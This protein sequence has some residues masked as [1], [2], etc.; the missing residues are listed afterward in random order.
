MKNACTSG[1]RAVTLVSVLGLLLLAAG[2]ACGGSR[3]SRPMTAQ[4]AAWAQYL[5]KWYPA[6][7]PPESSPTRKR[8]GTILRNGDAPDIETVPAGDSDFAPAEVP[9]GAAGVE[10]TLLPPAA[11]PAL[12]P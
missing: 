2:C 8:G 10:P 3:P 11:E 5:Q 6:W 7:R 9:S 12:A 1:T 4:E